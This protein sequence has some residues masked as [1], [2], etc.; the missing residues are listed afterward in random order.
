MTGSRM[1]GIQGTAAKSNDLPEL[2]PLK[3]AAEVTNVL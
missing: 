2:H 3:L 1:G